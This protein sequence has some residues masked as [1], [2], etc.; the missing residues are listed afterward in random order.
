M[1]DKNE[2]VLVACSGGLDSS[3][4]L[5]ILKLAGYHNMIACHFSYGH[6]GSAAEK[7]AIQ[8]VCSEL[9]V[10]LRIFDLESIYGEICIDN[11]SML[12]NEK[13][14]IVTGTTK[15]LKTTAA[16]TPAR[17]LL[18]LTVMGA[19]GEAEC[20]RHNY[21]TIYLAGGM[22]QLT[23]SATYPDNTPYFADAVKG[24]LKYGTLIG[25]RFKVLYCLSNLMKSE[26][27]VLIKEFGLEDVYRHTISCDRP[28]VRCSGEPGTEDEIVEARNCMKDGIPACGSGLLS[29][30]G[31]KMVGM[32][33][34]KLRNYYEVDDP[35]YKAHIPQ[36]IKDQFSKQPHVGSIIDRILLPEDKLDNLR[37][38][39]K[40]SNDN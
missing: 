18:F 16:W 39:L 22:L 9:Q 2:L 31:S 10:D 20:M 5:S 3:I 17:N 25:N 30:W 12:Q 6:R 19:L 14:E 28:T 40:E 37:R 4:T 27:F 23:E 38:M 29:Y 21:D 36:H 7:L 34:M 24:A 8:N 15:G 33:D 32:D 1:L 35:D 11:I 26:Q 13:S